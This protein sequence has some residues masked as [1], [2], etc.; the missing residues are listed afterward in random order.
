MARYAQ[1]LVEPDGQVAEPGYRWRGRAAKAISR[2]RF[3]TTPTSTMPLAPQARVPVPS[4]SM[5]YRVRCLHV[6][7]RRYWGTGQVVIGVVAELRVH[8]SPLQRHGRPWS[9]RRS[10]RPGRSGAEDAA[11]GDTRGEGAA[12]RT[13]TVSTHPKPQ[14][15]GRRRRTWRWPGSAPTSAAVSAYEVRP[16]GGTAPVP[17]TE[18]GR[19]ARAGLT[20]AQVHGTRG[21]TSKPTAT[22]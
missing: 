21:L 16:P 7:V 1:E 19:A 2:R 10:A 8:R 13:S 22:S 17:G 11:G 3:A 6:G 4:S 14:R 12:T 5:P 20:N 18:P 9:S 15:N